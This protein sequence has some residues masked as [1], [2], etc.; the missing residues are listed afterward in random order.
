MKR[1]VALGPSFGNYDKVNEKLGLPGDA[2]QVDWVIN[3]A[4]LPIFFYDPLQSIG[5][6]C[7]RRDAMRAA[8][9]GAAEHPIRLENQMRVKGGD[10]IYAMFAISLMGGAKAS[11][12]SRVTILSCTRTS[13]T[14]WTASSETTGTTI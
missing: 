7:V 1:R 9:G 8:L 3:Q 5:P 4:K 13:V 10:A 14:S 2:T 12:S 11:G 6:S